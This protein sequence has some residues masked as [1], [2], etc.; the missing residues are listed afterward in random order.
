MNVDEP[1]IFLYATSN[2][3]ELNLI[4]SRFNEEGIDFKIFGQQTSELYPIP[5]LEARVVVHDDNFAQA[6]LLLERMQESQ[7]TPNQ[8]LDFRDSTLEDIEYEKQVSEGN[9]QYKNPKLS[10]II[11]ILL[12]F[13][14]IYL[15]LTMTL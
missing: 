2:S 12:V 6:K 13:L 7:A 10:S 15:F 3:L 11:I 9:G 4:R 14:L 5:S 1:Y 8:D